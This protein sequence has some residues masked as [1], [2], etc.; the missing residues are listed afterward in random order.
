MFL[1][2]PLRTV[3]APRRCTIHHFITTVQYIYINTKASSYVRVFYLIKDDQQCN[4]MSLIM[5]TDLHRSFIVDIWPQG[6][7]SFQTN[8]SIIGYLNTVF[9]CSN[10]Q[11]HFVVLIC[12]FLINFLKVNNATWKYLK[13]IQRPC[14][15]STA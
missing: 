1:R 12:F 14:P 10:M 9:L 6:G 15:I 11:K 4:S 13:G 8:C 5:K 3:N 2:S 7:I